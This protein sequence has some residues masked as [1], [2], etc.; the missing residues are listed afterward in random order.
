MD[1]TDE[2]RSD[3]SAVLTAL[4]A[5]LARVISAIRAFG[6]TLPAQ[7]GKPRTEVPWFGDYEKVEE[8]K[9]YPPGPPSPAD[10]G[11]LLDW[12]ARPGVTLLAVDPYLLH[13]YWDFD[14]AEL[15]PDT[16]AAVLRFYDGAIHFDVDV[17]LRTRNWYVS[18]WSPAKTYYADLG[19]IA[20][21]GKF[22]PLLRSNT[23]QTSRAWP[24]AEVEHRFVSRAAVPEH[25]EEPVP[26]QPL[27]FPSERGGILEIAYRSDGSPTAAEPLAGEAE[28]AVC[29]SP[30][31]GHRPSPSIVTEPTERHVSKSPD[32]AEILRRKLA[33]F[34]EFRQREPQAQEAKAESRQTIPPLPVVPD[35]PDDLTAHVEREFSPG[36]SSLLLGARG[37]RKPAG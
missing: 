35:L 1:V 19:A 10:D 12:S 20:T 11:D 9:Y 13:V 23:I 33:E 34:H 27:P 8:A 37:P 7:A 4:R 29:F 17:D 21:A 24:A 26:P 6:A 2:S 16:T 14:L 28:P 5:A 15:P 18:L 32:A 36:L 22:I 30:A 31:T 25:F 3:D